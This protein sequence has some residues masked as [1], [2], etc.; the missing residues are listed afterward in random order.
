MPVHLHS[1]VNLYVVC[2]GRNGGCR[3]CD[4]IDNGKFYIIKII[5]FSDH[6]ISTDTACCQMLKGLDDSGRST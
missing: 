5:Y 2:Y 6:P 1:T 3:N 4:Q